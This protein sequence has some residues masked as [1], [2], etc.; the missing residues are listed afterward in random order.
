MKDRNHARISRLSIALLA[1]LAS[2]QA[3]AQDAPAQGTSSSADAATRKSQTVDA[4]TTSNTTTANDTE[5]AKQLDAIVVKGK[6]PNLGGGLMTMQT[7]PKAVSTVNR[8]AIA[9][10]A[11]GSNFTQAVATIPGVN[12]STDDVTGLSDGNYSLRGFSANEI[13][14]TVNGAP[15]SDSGSYSVFAT[16]YGDTENYGDITVEQGIPDL[17]QPDSGAAG[18]HI[19]WATI[20]PTHDAGIDFTQSGGSHD[21]ERTFFRFNTGDTG[22]VRSWISYSYNSVDKWRGAGDLAVYKIDG[23]SIWDISDNATISASFQFN[24]EVRDSYESL[25][26]SQLATCGYYCDYDK[27]YVPGSNDTSFYAL[28]TNPFRN[29]MA[30][31]DGEFQL[32]DNL[33]LTVIPYFQYGDGGAG[34]GN[35]FFAETS[36]TGKNEFEDANQD[37]N[38][39]GSIATGPN[40]SHAIAYGFSHSTTWRPG[41]L[42]KFKQ[43]IGADNSLE[44]GMWYERPRQ[45]QSQT[46][47]LANYETGI[48]GNLWGNGSY[49]VYPDGHIQETYNEYTQ[50][51]TQK[52][53]VTDTWTPSDQWLVSLGAA[54]LRVNRSGFD[55]QYPDNQGGFEPPQFG[56]PDIDK[57]F[58]KVTPAFGIRFSPDKNNQF[59]YG[60]GETFRAPPNTA[61]AL[62]EAAGRPDNVPETAWNNDIGWR[63]YG[64]R[65]AANLMLYRSNFRD[66]TITGFDENTGLSF[67]TEINR[68]RMQGF[69]A[70]ASFD[71]SEH[72]KLYGS[73]AYT[74]ATVESNTA[75]GDDGIY[76]TKGKQLF[77]TPHNIAYG[78][79]SYDNGSFWAG[80]NGRFR[81]SIYGD[82]MNTERVGGYATFG[83]DAGYR[84]HDWNSDLI[85]K[86]FIKVNIYNIFSRHALTNAN[87]A[88]SY[89]ASNPDHLKDINGVTLFASAP[90]YSLLEPRSFM[91]TFGASFF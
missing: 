43:D 37:L 88:S 68:L 12:A 56:A 11:P 66:K 18:G 50:T 62:N 78:A 47:G 40:G 80:A 55:F 32:S 27:T 84:F 53:F 52:Y 23:K 49:I 90:Y 24:H 58:D 51:E 34:T 87:N 73:Y 15:I 67:Y 10:E 3:F 54:Y 20:N 65:F 70:E 83:L 17:D 74:D 4:S 59:Y 6:R 82:F 75:A 35:K 13:G 57:T 29:Y 30:S 85:K 36:F 38:Q 89:L 46:W 69:D 79:I 8:D 19:A 7:A 25:T 31:L 41:I 33:H 21:Y 77:N 63:F 9:K 39:D 81:D 1:A 16:E 5:R 91:V 28:H 60:V 45:E 48:P 76:P 64:D 42:A 14:V 86:P 22:P 72:W 61:I 44:Y 26:K 71:L 2:T